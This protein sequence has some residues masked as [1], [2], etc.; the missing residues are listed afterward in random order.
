M[1]TG[2]PPTKRVAKWLLELPVD[3][4]RLRKHYWPGGLHEVMLKIDEQG[5]AQALHVS[6]L[7]ETERKRFFEGAQV[8]GIVDWAGFS[9]VWRLDDLKTGAAP[10]DWSE[11][12]PPN[13]LPETPPA[14]TP[15]LLIYGD[16]WLQLHPHEPGVELS[17]TRWTRYPKAT[18]PNVIGPDWVTRKYL[19]EWHNE[20][21]I[22]AE[23]LAK[24]P[25][26][27]HLANP[28]DW[29]TFCRSA[30]YCSAVGGVMVSGTVGDT[31]VED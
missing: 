24:G 3:P 19:K 8:K 21:Y 20:V 12:W 4:E 5:Q 7:T 11:G 14:D 1:E 2:F 30:P 23:R 27:I 25:D 13:P 10:A 6:P 29:C 9:F 22:P 18:L 28:G 31:H 17:L 26:A 15:Q 16:I